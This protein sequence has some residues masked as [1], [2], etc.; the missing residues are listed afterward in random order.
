MLTQICTR[1][2]RKKKIKIQLNKKMYFNI[3]QQT[4]K[5]HETK[6]QQTQQINTKKRTAKKKQT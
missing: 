5:L 4:P 3:K 6:K 1:P 2:P